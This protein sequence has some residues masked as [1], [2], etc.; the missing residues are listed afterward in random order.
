MS[1]PLYKGLC[2]E[3]GLYESVPRHTIACIYLILCRCA[4]FSP[5]YKLGTE[6][7]ALWLEIQGRNMAWCLPAFDEVSNGPGIVLITSG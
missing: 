1:D 2:C 5:I 6:K 4:F 7:H 3:V